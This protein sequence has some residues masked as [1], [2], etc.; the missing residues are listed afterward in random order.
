MCSWGFIYSKT[1]RFLLKAKRRRLQ[2]QSRPALKA[3]THYPVADKDTEECLL[4]I[5]CALKIIPQHG[6]HGPRL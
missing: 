2:Q 5:C 4:Q 3:S 1:S 6:K